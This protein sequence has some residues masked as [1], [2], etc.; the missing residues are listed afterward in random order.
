MKINYLLL[1]VLFG[2]TFH[3]E[4]QE[5]TG[6][7][8]KGKYDYILP[9]HLDKSKYEDLIDNEDSS[10]VLMD[11]TILAYEGANSNQY[12]QRKWI[13]HKVYYIGNE[14]DI[15]EIN[16]LY[17]YAGS[18][19][20]S[21]KVSV[22]TTT[23]DGREIYLDESKMEDVSREDGAANYKILAISGIEKHSF[24]EVLV[25]RENQSSH[26]R[27]S[28]SNPFPTKRAEVFVHNSEIVNR[29]YPKIKVRFNVYG[30]YEVESW[31]KNEDE[32]AEFRKTFTLLS[33]RDSLLVH[34][35]ASAVDIRPSSNEDYSHEYEGYTYVDLVDIEY[36]WQEAGE[37]IG[38]NIFNELKYEMN[39]RKYIKDLDLDEK[40]D[41]EKIRAIEKFIKEDIKETQSGD[42]EYSSTKD[43]W[44]KRIANETGLIKM[45]DQMFNAAGLEYK[46]YLCSDKDY[47]QIDPHFAFTSGMD[48]ILFYFPILDV[49]MIPTNGYYYAGKIP[50]YLAS[51]NALVIK[52]I[53]PLVSLGEVVRLPEAKMEDNIDGTLAIIDIDAINEN[54]TVQK[55]KFL[56]GDRATR[57][58]GY[59]H[60]SDDADREEYVR[61]W[62]VDDLEMELSEVEIKN[63]SIDLN[64]GSSDTVYYSGVLKGNDILS[65]IP[66]GFI[67]NPGGIMGTQVS[68]YDT[69]DRISDIYIPESKMY[70][71]TI[72]INIPEGYTVE[73]TENLEFDEKYFV[74]KRWLYGQTAGDVEEEELAD[75]IAQFVSTVEVKDNQLIIE[76]DEFYL[77]GFYPKE[78][79]EDLQKVVNA[80]YEFFIAKVKL[81]EM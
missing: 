6:M 25:S 1:L 7:Y 64:F 54:C 35:I 38:R 74:N 70:D 80:A 12:Y 19:S 41:L 50:N 52:E 10:F 60:F 79:L 26:K 17:L 11:R 9:V 31:L 67:L 78:G 20:N 8:Q 33:H 69:E 51:V 23:S 55:T 30:S 53:S 48:D 59:Y 34:P 5:G 58:R 75:P 40:S 16:K 73:G 57:S 15:E 14:A 72:I 32:W 24:V 18:S 77:E 46:I 28:V 62:L 45:A 37:G 44:R 42:S 4:A 63:E 71:H 2:I 27:F 49:Y 61:E 39:G 66:N 21:M 43:I 68:F 81:V 76:I 22:R 65:S 56:Y 29:R 36:D 3:A 47:V 13:S